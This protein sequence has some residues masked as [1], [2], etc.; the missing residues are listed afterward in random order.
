MGRVARSL[1]FLDAVTVWPLFII[2][3]DCL[4]NS[5][6]LSTIKSCVFTNTNHHNQQRKQLT[7]EWS[8]NTCTTSR[9]YNSPHC[10][11]SP[12]GTLVG[13]DLC[14]VFLV[15]RFRFT[16]PSLPCYTDS[17]RLASSFFFQKKSQ[18]SATTYHLMLFP[19]RIETK[20]LRTCSFL[21]RSLIR[22]I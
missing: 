1:P 8:S 18:D 9:P 16:H 4:S 3:S 7:G 17:S 19:N 14:C 22:Q 12:T 11:T 13:A 2:A 6:C 15:C 21:I 10:S 20:S 5:L